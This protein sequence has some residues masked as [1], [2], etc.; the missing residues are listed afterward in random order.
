MP[1]TKRGSAPF[2][3]SAHTKVNPAY[4]S[5]S[6]STSST[7]RVGV[8]SLFASK[9]FKGKI[10]LEGLFFV[11]F[12]IDATFNTHENL[13]RA[14]SIPSHVPPPRTSLPANTCLPSLN[15]LLLAARVSRLTYSSR[16]V[17]TT[18]GKV[19]CCFTA[20]KR[21][22]MPSLWVGVAGK[23]LVFAGTTDI[24]ESSRTDK[25][26]HR[27]REEERKEQEKNKKKETKKNEK[28]KKIKKR[29]K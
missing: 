11:G 23:P 24:A 13:P 6:V 25:H 12:S 17:A 22:H 28:R 1:N 29:K 5:P 2:I 4:L 16:L 3:L 18:R 8:A 20:A 7:I 15:N 26:L 9:Y 10:P 19:A 27:C 14:V 21:M